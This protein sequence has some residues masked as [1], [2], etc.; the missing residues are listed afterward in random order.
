MSPTPLSLLSDK[1]IDTL[2]PPLPGS[3][4]VPTE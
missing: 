1:V 2:H 4:E 3:A